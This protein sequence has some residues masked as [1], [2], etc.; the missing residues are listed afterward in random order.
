M[1]WIGVDF[2]GTLAEWHGDGDTRN[3]RPIPLMVERV[4][5]MLADGKDVRIFTARASR[6][7]QNWYKQYCYVRDWCTEYIGQE[8][9][10]TAEKDM[11]LVE[12]WDDL[13]VQV[14]PN[15]GCILDYGRHLDDLAARLGD[16]Y[17]FGRHRSIWPIQPL[18]HTISVDASGIETSSAD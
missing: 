15:T 16:D 13:A 9:R 18:R 17:V 2:D 3:G 14:Q 1:G 8:L 5:K 10:W 12:F 7:N 6:S 11:D 4:K